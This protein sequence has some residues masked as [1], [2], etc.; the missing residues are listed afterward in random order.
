MEKSKIVKLYE[1]KQF[2]IS[3]VNFLNTLKSIYTEYPEGYAEVL[4][5]SKNE[6]D[7]MMLQIKEL[8]SK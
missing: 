7:T 5:H 1:L 2:L 8:V 4:N 3:E 6:I